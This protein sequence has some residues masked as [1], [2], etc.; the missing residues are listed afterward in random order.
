MEQRLEEEG[1]R[2]TWSVEQCLEQE[3]VRLAWSTEQ[4]LEEE[5][6]RPAWRMEQRLE[7]EGVRPA[8]SVE[9]RPS[10]FVPP[11]SSACFDSWDSAVSARSM[12]LRRPPAR[13]R[14]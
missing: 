10:I 3:G 11:A 1:I 8:W 13:L 2:P 5:G 6:V 4:S 14:Q 7:E 9:Q 12:H